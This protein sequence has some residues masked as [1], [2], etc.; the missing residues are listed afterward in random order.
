NVANGS[1]MLNQF[2]DGEL[3]SSVQTIDSEIDGVGTYIMASNGTEVSSIGVLTYDD[4]SLAGVVANML[5]I[6]VDSLW[7]NIYGN[8]SSPGDVLTLQSD[9]TTKFQAPSGGGGATNA[10]NV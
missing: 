3:R 4:Y 10:E 5:T 7:I 6:S 8:T 2:K 1:F 9:G